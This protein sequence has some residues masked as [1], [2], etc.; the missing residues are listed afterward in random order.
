VIVTLRGLPHIWETFITI[1]NN[2]I[3]SSFDEIVGKL[4][5]EESKMI[6]VEE[7]R[8]IMYSRILLDLIT[9]CEA[10]LQFIFVSLI[11]FSYY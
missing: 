3:F 5:Q 1:S 4:T 7:S 2:N 9:I 11:F 6:F 8:A 10:L